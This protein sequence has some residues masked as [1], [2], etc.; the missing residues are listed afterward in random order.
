MKNGDSLG[1]Y[2]IVEKIGEGGMGEVYRAHDS[3]L[4]REVAVKI[5]PAH[6]ADDPD[7]RARFDR[8]S[9][10][11]AAL[12]HPNILAIFDVG[13]AGSVT[14]AVTELLEG[15]S[16][17]E[18]VTRGPLP[19]RKALEIAVQVARGLSAAHDK[20]IVHRD[21]KP[22]N[23]FILSDGRAKILDFGLA[24][25]APDAA[26][27][28]TGTE[29]GVVMGTVGYMA[30][31]QVRAQPADARTDL[32][33][34]GVVLHEMLSGRRAFQRDTPAES[35]T[36]I[37]REDPPELLV[38][39]SDISPALDRIVR[40]CV[41]KNPTER[42]QTARDVAFA[43]EALSGS[44]ASGMSGAARAT[45]MGRRG[46]W[47]WPVAAAVVTFLAMTGVLVWDR[48]HRHVA[49]P[50][51]VMKTFEPQTMISARF[52]PDGMTFAYTA[53]ADSLSQTFLVRPDRTAPEPIGT[54]G[55]LLA[56]SGTG[57]L[58][59]LV[60][61]VADR[62]MAL[63]TLAR[64]TIGGAPRRVRER[65]RWADWAPDG[66][67]MAVV[68]DVGGRDRLEYPIGTMLYET[69]GT[70]SMVRVSP[71]GERVAFSDHPLRGDIRGWIKVVDRAGR[72][73]SLAGEY[74]AQYGLAWSP[75]GTSVVFSASTGDLD[76]PLWVRAVY[77][78]PASGGAPA[79]LLLDAPGG[80]HV[81]DVNARGELL[82]G[83]SDIGTGIMVQRPGAPREQNLSWMSGSF[84]P[85]LSRDGG[86]VAFQREVGGAG[87]GSDIFLRKTDGSP[88]LRVGQG[89]V[90]GLSPDGS[91]VLALTVTPGSLVVYPTGTG[92]RTLLSKGPIETYL[93][94]GRWF[95]DGERILT[96]GTES[97]RGSRCYEQRVGGSPKAVTPE[98]LVGAALSVD[99]RFL[100]G[101][102]SNHT[103]QVVDLASGMLRPT[104]GLQPTDV[105][106][107]WSSDGS[108]AFV[109]RVPQV[110]ARLERVN[111]QTG[112]RTFIR[113]LAP[114]DRAGVSVIV[115][116]SI[117]DDARGYA[118]FYV[119][120]V[121]TWYVVQDTGLGR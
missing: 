17:R 20:G 8:E 118:Y 68:Q 65:I 90:L 27:T 78:V 51:Y 10:A 52:L 56:I 69:P 97:G 117:I 86:L 57:E 88:A 50:R 112:V 96:C 30:P 1:P 119:R 61:R 67:S 54:P 85:T 100:L 31:E 40:H 14:Y 108:A 82:A 5:L 80:L 121:A 16:L 29:P 83:R 89:N 63:G 4:H 35:M 110:P 64:L 99:G 58:A 75:A 111:L 98:G 120:D 62:G 84:A 32:F 59:V 43:L 115:P 116:T 22:E 18:H 26:V 33:S 24:Q 103:W 12:S 9:R 113:E 72:V 60:D 3:R 87:G 49:R 46:R 11:V 95:P 21:L 77:S 36:A 91:K 102:D 6:V 13:V 66:N 106:A 44:T 39:R 38:T 34:L 42:F 15:E 25:T 2:R 53:V 70:V 37:L 79:E 107:G 109:A 7:R 105:A 55:D 23:V 93:P 104:A 28:A 74:A 92:E 101:Q 81:N 94:V 41:E 45:P 76:Q 114:P 47:L 48:T 73:V 19:V 71:D